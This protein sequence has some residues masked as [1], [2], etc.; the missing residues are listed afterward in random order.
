VFPHAIVECNHMVPMSRR[1]LLHRSPGFAIAGARAFQLAGIGVDDIAHVD[2]YSCFP[3]AVRTQ[4]LELGLATT[5]PLTVTGGMTF[6]GGPLNN[7]TLQSA[8]KMMHV[9][10]ADPG[11][12]GLVTAVSG[13]ITKQAVS[14]WSTRPPA[15][16]YRSAEVSAESAAATPEVALVSGARGA[17]TV[18]TYTVLAERDGTPARGVVVVDVPGGGRA[19]AVTD[20]A[21]VAAAMTQGEWCGRPVE[22]D[23]TGGFA[24]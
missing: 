9:L 21:P 5:R 11:S 22:L 19:I 17:A 2:L 3:I 8:A 16:G 15:G 13:M 18:A 24:P 23:G 20:A 6:A 10:R 1:G 14:V 12:L 4:A 7:Y